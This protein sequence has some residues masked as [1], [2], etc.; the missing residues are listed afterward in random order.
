MEQLLKEYKTQFESVLKAKLNYLCGAEEPVASGV[1]Y[2]LEG[3]KRI[4]P[5]LVMLGAD[6][7]EQDVAVNMDLACG[8]EC[9]HNYSLVHDDLPCMDNDDYR[10]GQLSTHKKFGV[11]MGVLIGDALLNL[12]FEIMLASDERNADYYKAVKYIATQSGIMG[13]IG[14][15]CID[16]KEQSLRNG[17]LDEVIKL[18]ELKTS[19]LFK[20]SLVGSCIA[21][22]ATD[23]EIN[24]LTEY[25]NCLGLIFQLVDDI[26]DNT[27]TAEEL[28]KDI[29][30]DA[31]NNKI[32]YL[33]LMGMDNTKRQIET[34][35][36]KAIAALEKYGRR[37]DKL[38][39]LCVYLTNRSK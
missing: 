8:M 4:R 19:A 20:A 23:E 16:I 6:F 18:N 34:L 5:V 32:T 33:S 36:K 2:A 7:M 10:H 14:G 37:A 21:C 25:V 17:T 39:N 35:E 26:L 24:D 12:A 9:I 38:I 1:R 31:E 13:M 30:S 27:A 28:G 3:G 11:G 22:G 15:Q 29:G